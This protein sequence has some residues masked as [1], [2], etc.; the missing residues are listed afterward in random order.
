MNTKTV[1]VNKNSI[2]YLYIKSSAYNEL[3]KLYKEFLENRFSYNK[4]KSI[5]FH[6]IIHWLRL[7]PYKIEKDSKRVAMFYAGLIIVINEVMEMYEE[8]YCNE[9]EISNL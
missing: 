1:E 6:E 8:E 5:F 3:F 4:V 9:K 7:M 2:N